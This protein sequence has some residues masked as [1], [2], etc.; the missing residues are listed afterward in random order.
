MADLGL[1]C[2]GKCRLHPPEIKTGQSEGKHNPTFRMK[3]GVGFIHIYAAGL[4][5]GKLPNIGQVSHVRN[6]Q[7]AL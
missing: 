6:R 3:R 1:S 5:T 7:I 2:Q 4:H